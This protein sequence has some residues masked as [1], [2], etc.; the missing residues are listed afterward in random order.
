LTEFSLTVTVCIILKIFF[1]K[2]AFHRE[3]MRRLAMPNSWI[4]LLDP[5][6]MV[7]VYVFCNGSTKLTFLYKI[8]LRIVWQGLYIP[9]SVPAKMASG[10]STS[11]ATLYYPIPNSHN[12]IET[13]DAPLPYA[14]QGKLPPPCS[15]LFTFSFL[16]QGSNIGITRVVHFRFRGRT[17]NHMT[18]GKV[19]KSII[20]ERIRI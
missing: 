2:A 15:T 18:L 5:I 7:S 14:F 10:G 9:S 19:K 20:I 16:D 12:I 11:S 3:D 4:C 13:H 17:A 6:S 1:I 8:E